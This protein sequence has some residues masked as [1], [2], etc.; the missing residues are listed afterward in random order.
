MVV[1]CKGCEKKRANYK[2]KGHGKPLMY[3]EDCKEGNLIKSDSRICLE[4]GCSIRS[5]F[6]FKNKKAEFCR[7]HA[8]DGMIDVFNKRCETKGCT[9]Y[10]FF[11]YAGQPR[12][13][14]K[15]HI[16]EGMIS[17]IVKK[18]EFKGCNKRPN[19]NY[20]SQ[21]FP[22]F[23]NDHKKEN[24]VNV[25][26]KKCRKVGCN[27]QP[28]FNYDGQLIPKFCKNHK[29]ENM[30]NVRHK[31]CSE[32]G[33]S[34]LPSYNYEGQ[35][36]KFCKT[37]AKEDMVNVVSKKCEV[38]GCAKCPNFNY[39]S[40]LRG[41]FCKDHSL[42]NMINVKS[43]KCEVLDCN[44]QPSFNYKG[45][46]KRF[47]KDHILK[48]MVDVTHILCNQD[49]CT[50]RASYSLLFAPSPT[51]CA[52]HK[53]PNMVP[54]RKRNPKCQHE[55]SAQCTEQPT[56]AP[57][58]SN[59]PTHCEEH[60]PATHINIIETPCE[61]CGLP[62]YIPEGET[63]CENCRGTTFQ[64]YKESKELRIK[65]VL[66]AHNIPITAHDKIPEGAC[67]KKRPDF[68]IDCLTFFLIVEVDENQHNPNSTNY[69][70]ECEISRMLQ[71]HQ[72]FGG[73]PVVFIRYNPDAY[74]DHLRKRH[75]GQT[76]NPKRE[77][78]LINLIQKIMKKTDVPTGVSVYYLYYDQD[79]GIDRMMMMDYFN[80]K[81]EE[82][83]ELAEE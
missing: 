40:K 32:V 51:H 33:C 68:V 3:C 71:I 59:Y 19:F 63:K 81:V 15:N 41:R 7:I 69:S 30:I 22:K 38:M 75:Q 28:N 64:V 65:A 83:I 52:K 24:M 34:K 44:K 29:K 70:C 11:N 21:L 23:C 55:S 27:K 10:A 6:G 82:V 39:P 57:P 76:Q 61:S 77:R 8:L 36:A 45:M 48:D 60:A 74:M 78:R 31:K 72:D 50:T 25:K 58:N 35:I 5:L 1:W 18:C 4:E 17:V 54:A 79:D 9:N 66:E 47:C 12:K 16:K 46:P 56:H 80:Y 49:N 26:S 43:K 14:C 73:P 2:E 20:G 42:E 53:S 62:Y 37:H 67:S 13:F